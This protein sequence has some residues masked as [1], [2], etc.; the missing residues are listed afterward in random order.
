MYQLQPRQWNVKTNPT[1][2]LREV[3][4]IASARIHY[5]DGARPRVPS[6]LTDPLVR[7]HPSERDAIENEM[8]Q[9]TAQW[10]ELKPYTKLL[11]C[12][13]ARATILRQ[14]DRTSWEDFELI[15]CFDLGHLR[16]G[17][18]FCINVEVQR[19]MKH[20]EGLVTLL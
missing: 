20:E 3:I 4:D 13:M 6:V 10:R 18:G 12:P 14:S 19:V 2:M 1:N 9:H 15:R 16:V 17:G 8:R 5:I 11:L 7:L